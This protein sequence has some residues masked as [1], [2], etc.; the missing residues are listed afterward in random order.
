MGADGGIR[1]SKVSE[2][3]EEWVDIRENLVGYFSR[4]LE[5]CDDWEKKFIQDD[6]NNSVN[7]PMSIE[8]MTGEEICKV[9]SVYKSCDCPHLLEGNIITGYGDYVSN[10]M[11]V[12]SRTLPGY[13][14]ET[15]T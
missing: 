6:Y 5:K 12:M 3:T 4:K 8:G 14:V 1:I 9:L 13:Y 11:D 2:I 15:W 7:L 10:R